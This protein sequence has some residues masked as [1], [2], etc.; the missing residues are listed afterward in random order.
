LTTSKQGNHWLD[1][2]AEK[3]SL[4]KVEEIKH[5]LNLLVLFI[6]IPLFWALFG[7]FVIV[8]KSDDSLILY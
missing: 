1:A 3:Y 5:L 6:P 7:Q 8:L 4:E 2:A